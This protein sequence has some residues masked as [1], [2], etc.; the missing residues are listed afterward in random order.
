[1]PRFKDQA[2]CIRLF[3]WSETSQVVGLLTQEHG[4]VRGLAKGSKRTSP[5]CVARYSGGIELLTMGQV[6]ATIRPTSDLATITE[7]DLQETWRHFRT[8][9]EAQRLGLFA[10][11]LAGAMLADHDSH[12]GAFTALRDVLSALGEPSQRDAALLTYQWRMLVECGY[13]PELAQDVLAGAVLE[14]R[15]TFNFDPKAGGL[16]AQGAAQSDESGPGPWRVRRETV[17]ALRSVAAASVNVDPSRA[18]TSADAASPGLGLDV[19]AVGRANR[20]LYAYARSILDRE[21][22][23]AAFLFDRGD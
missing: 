18:V 2:I 14:D 13:R 1:M 22:P 10:V 5:G 19:S 23:T 21:L 16:T 17:L 3:D 8:D 11:D 12:P 4:K 7:W 6:V 20:L 9:L 15:A